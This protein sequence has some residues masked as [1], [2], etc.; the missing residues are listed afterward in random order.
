MSRVRNNNNA[1]ASNAGTTVAEKNDNASLYAE[2][3]QPT[4]NTLQQNNTNNISSK[5]TQI[6]EASNLHLHHTTD[7]TNNYTYPPV[8][9]LSGVSGAGKTTTGRLL[10]NRLS[11]VLHGNRNNNSVPAYEY[12]E[13]DDYHSAESKDKMSRGIPL[14]DLDRLPWLERLAAAIHQHITEHHPCIVAC[15]ALKH[16][17]RHMLTAAGTGTGTDD[18]HHDTRDTIRFVLLNGSEELLQQRMLAR[19]G[20]FMKENLLRSQINTLE[21][22]LPDEN[23]VVVDIK[24]SPDVIVDNIMKEIAVAKQQHQEDA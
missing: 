18:K 4:V 24:P 13:G 2:S 1:V 16:S 14:T 20:H 7:D 8:I 9:I 21:P 17:Y 3:C 11:H 22:P 5:N 10:Q 12:I 19:K 15:S 6:T 23:I